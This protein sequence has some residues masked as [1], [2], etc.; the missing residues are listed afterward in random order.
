MKLLQQFQ[1]RWY[2]YE[3]VDSVRTFLKQ[4]IAQVRRSSPG[5]GLSLRG[6]V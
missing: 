1:D 2:G 6:G 5:A 3:R 4:S